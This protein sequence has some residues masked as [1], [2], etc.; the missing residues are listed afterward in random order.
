MHRI[1]VVTFIAASIETCFDLARSVKTHE[2]T[3]RSTSET[4]TSTS[5]NDL[6]EEGD[7]VTFRARHLGVYWKLTARITKMHRPE[8]FVDEQTSGPFRSLR[9]EHRFEAAG[10]GTQMTDILTFAVPAPIVGRWIGERI[11]KPH[12]QAFLERRNLELRRLAE[13]CDGS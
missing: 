13:E 12:L 3:A 4:A 8:S 2:S 6:L 5:G 1:E 9:H 10:D 11:L 7:E